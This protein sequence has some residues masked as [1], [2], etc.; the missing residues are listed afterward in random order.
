MMNRILPNALGV[1]LV[2]L[3][4]LV[5]VVCFVQANRPETPEVDRG[6]TVAKEDEYLAWRKLD[7][8]YVQLWRFKNESNFRFQFYDVEN[9]QY[10]SE[11]Y[12]V[13]AV[14]REFKIWGCD[15]LP[16]PNGNPDFLQGRI[17]IPIRF[18]DTV[19]KHVYFEP[20]RRELNKKAYS[21]LYRHIGQMSADFDGSFVF[22][23]GVVGT[24]NRKVWKGDTALEAYALTWRH[25]DMA[26]VVRWDRY[27]DTQRRLCEDVRDKLRRLEKQANDEFKE[28]DRENAKALGYLD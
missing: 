22:S 7:T 2:F 6:P 12:T 15:P 3:V 4:L 8:G 11:E 28:W 5:M 21:V 23:S 14:C 25:A 16:E 20:T 13:A 17:D 1:L 19:F 26:N 18:Y 10:C 27:I 24:K 9:G